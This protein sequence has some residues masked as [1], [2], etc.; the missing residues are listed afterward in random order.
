MRRLLVAGLVTGALLVLP[1][2][3][4]AKGPS[5]ALING[6]GLA[7][8]LRVDGA[9]DLGGGDLG[10]PGQF[11]DLM[12]H[13]GFSEGVWGPQAG[14]PAAEEPAGELG[15]RYT[16]TWTLPGPSGAEDTVRQDLYPFAEVGAVTYVPPDQ[17]F[18]DGQ[19][20]PGGWFAGGAELSTLL[21]DLGLREPA[22]PPPDRFGPL[23]MAAVVGVIL[24]VACAAAWMAARGRRR[25]AAAL[26]G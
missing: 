21:L 10:R 24:A 11:G 18:F 15:P 13:A 8:P 17:L 26:P 20:T 4:L 9:S 7:A 14:A 12:Q 1:G 19:R 5:E 25:P 3:A 16:V 2:T 22:P 23:P 6:P